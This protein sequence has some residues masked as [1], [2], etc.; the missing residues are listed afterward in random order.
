MSL[1]PYI[2]R[3]FARPLRL[4]DQQFGLGVSKDDFCLPYTIPPEPLS[5]S[6]M[7]YYRPWRT[8]AAE[9][10]IGSTINLVKHVFEINL[11]VQHFSPE[12]IT[13]K[14]N[15]D[16]FIIVDASHAEK[17]DEHGFISRHFVR[18]YLL[19]NGANINQITSS[20]SS[21]GVLKITAPRLDEN[22]V[23]ERIIPIQQTGIPSR[24]IYGRSFKKEGEGDIR[25]K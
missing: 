20:L 4:L 15:D 14:V 8:S 23:P 17:E 25:P 1:I 18:K 10:D 6:R 3:D 5:P 16:G 21:D 12:E 7:Q 13:V 22:I 24:N 19:P 9:R 2:L 11:D